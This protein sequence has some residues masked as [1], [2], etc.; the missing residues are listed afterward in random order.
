MYVL[1]MQYQGEPIYF[2]KN[3]TFGFPEYTYYREQATTFQKKAAELIKAVS[4]FYWTL[5]EIV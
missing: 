4:M 3:R 2:L 5:E 1:T